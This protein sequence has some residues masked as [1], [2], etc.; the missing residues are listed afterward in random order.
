MSQELR[1][2]VNERPMTVRVGTTTREAA[3]AHDPTLAQAL[4]AGAANVTDG[5]GRPVDAD[6][7]VEEGAIVRVVRSVSRA[8]KQRKKS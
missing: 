2:F 6:S 1:I 5:V 4:G 3:V 7:L 8:S